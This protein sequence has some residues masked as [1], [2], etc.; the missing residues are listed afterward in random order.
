MYTYEGHHLH[1]FC[2]FGSFPG[3]FLVGKEGLKGHLSPPKMTPKKVWCENEA[4]FI[5]GPFLLNNH[6][7]KKVLQKINVDGVR[8]HVNST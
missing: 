6:Q 8:E 2:I 5:F 1:L 7:T 3:P 4:A